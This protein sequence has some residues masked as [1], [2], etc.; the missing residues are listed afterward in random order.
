MPALL[1]ILFVKKV[2]SPIGKNMD[3]GVFLLPGEADGACFMGV[4]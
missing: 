2:L 4:D 1:E 3:H